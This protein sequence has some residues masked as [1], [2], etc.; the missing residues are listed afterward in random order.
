[1]RDAD[2]DQEAG[3]V[4]GQR[5][6]GAGAVGRLLRLE[7]ESLPEQRAGNDAA[8]GQT[9]LEQVHPPAVLRRPAGPDDLGAGDE[10]GELVVAHAGADELLGDERAGTGGDAVLLDNA[11]DRRRG[12]LLD[13]VPV[14]GVVGDDR[15]VRRPGEVHDDGAVT[16][17][18]GVLDVAHVVGD[19]EGS[20]GGHDRR[21]GGPRPI[22]VLLDARGPHRLGAEGGRDGGGLRGL[23]Q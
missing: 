1:M 15:V 22:L 5:D 7:G 12:H 20:V 18:G 2:G 21:V 17:Q 14:L 11:S 13:A 8:V 16:G 3:A 23:G 19:E 4:G 10:I 9:D 6:R